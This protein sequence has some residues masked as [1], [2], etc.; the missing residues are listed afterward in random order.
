[1]H[2]LESP[3]RILSENVTSNNWGI[4]LGHDLNHSVTFFCWFVW[5]FV[6]IFFW[7]F[8]GGFM[9]KYL[10]RVKQNGMENV[11]KK[12]MMPDCKWWRL[13]YCILVDGFYSTKFGNKAGFQFFGEPPKSDKAPPYYTEMPKTFTNQPNDFSL[14]LVKWETWNFKKDKHSE[15]GPTI[16]WSTYDIQRPI[17]REST[18][19][20]ELLL[21]QHLSQM[22]Q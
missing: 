3:G 7:S 6:S 9:S 18:P 22:N 1:M 17:F 13:Y 10:G 20:I 5:G 2:D 12:V 14:C 15:I 19:K 21:C 11:E 8:W 4:K 16:D